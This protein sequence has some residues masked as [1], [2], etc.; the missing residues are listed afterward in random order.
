MPK[1]RKPPAAANILTLPE[2]TGRAG[3]AAAGHI[4]RSRGYKIVRT[5][6]RVREGE[7]DL[8]TERDGQIVFVEV[9][10]RRSKSFGSPEESLT[11]E[12]AARL[13]AAAQSYLS[14]TGNEQAD[15][16]IDFLGIEM[17][18]SGRVVHSNLVENA[19]AE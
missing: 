12:K 3:E 8:V 2:G 5:N 14:D 16:R 19:I 11:A 6:Y 18:R 7:I 4:L 9:K 17:D 10:T 13:I 1:T 15:W